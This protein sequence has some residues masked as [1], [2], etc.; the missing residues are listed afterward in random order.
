MLSDSR[1][2]GTGME[3]GKIPK[4]K[5][6]LS[7]NRGVAVELLRSGRFWI[8]LKIE[9]L[10]FLDRVKVGCVNQESDYPL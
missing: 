4:I 7:Q 5:M 10:G 9:P 1:L 2:S 3:A 6:M 8:D